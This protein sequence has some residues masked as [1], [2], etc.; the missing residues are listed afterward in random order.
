MFAAIKSFT[1]IA[2]FLSRGHLNAADLHFAVLSL[3]QL[4][5]QSVLHPTWLSM[6]K[7]N[8]LQNW[9]QLNN[10]FCLIHLSLFNVIEV[11]RGTVML[12]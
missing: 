7:Y 3:Y 12:K 2:E 10:S 5:S 8:Q 11:N 4:C 1:T 6:Y 9:S